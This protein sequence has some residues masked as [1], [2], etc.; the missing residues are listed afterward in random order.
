MTGQKVAPEG[1]TVVSTGHSVVAAGQLVAATG[2]EVATSGHTV[3]TSGEM[4]VPPWPTVI[5]NG[6]AVELMKD[7]LQSA[8]YPSLK[9][10]Y[11]YAVWSSATARVN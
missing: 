4:V 10:G 1:H 5:V 9:A 3:A 7:K 2:Q 11:P 8:I 6:A